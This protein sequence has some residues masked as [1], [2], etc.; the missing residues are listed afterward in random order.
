LNTDSS[1]QY[2]NVLGKTITVRPTI[3]HPIHVDT[4]QRTHT[5]MLG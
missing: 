1:P 5:V 2:A 4:N 3:V